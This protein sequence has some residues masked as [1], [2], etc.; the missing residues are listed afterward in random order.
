MSILYPNIKRNLTEDDLKVIKHLTSINKL[1]K[2]GNLSIE[3]LF[4]DNGCFKVIKEVDGKEYEVAWFGDIT[5]DGGDPDIYGVNGI[6]SS[7]ELETLYDE[8]D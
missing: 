6:Y 4:V 3:M 5:C 7:D 1:F 2:K 8:Q